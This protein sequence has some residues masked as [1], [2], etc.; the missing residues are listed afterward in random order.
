MPFRGNVHGLADG[1]AAPLSGQGGWCDGDHIP[2]R[3]RRVGFLQRSRLG[4]RHHL[5]R[6]RP[7]LIR[8]SAK[9]K[10]LDGSPPGLAHSLPLRKKRLFADGI[11]VR[12]ERNLGEEP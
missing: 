10:H 5:P 4:P 8:L 2:R 6:S 11:F 9:G 7:F 1:V 12:A 3:A